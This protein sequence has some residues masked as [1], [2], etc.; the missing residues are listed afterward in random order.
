MSETGFDNPHTK[1]VIQTPNVLVGM[2]DQGGYVTD[3]LV[4]HPETGLMVPML[5]VHPEKL[6]RTGIPP[7]VPN[8]GPS[9][10]LGQ[11]GFGRESNWI[12]IPVSDTTGKM[13]LTHEQLSDEARA[14][15]PHK[16]QSEISVSITGPSSIRYQM[17]LKN[18]DNQPIKIVPGIHPYFAV[19]ENE[20]QN[21]KVHGLPAYNP[22]KYDWQQSFPDNEYRFNSRSLTV[23]MADRLITIRRLTGD[24]DANSRVTIWSEQGL[25]ALCVEPISGSPKRLMDHQPLTLHPGKVWVMD[26]EMSAEFKKAA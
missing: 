22:G 21:V 18:D 3:W 4:R 2:R 17:F 16:F 15:Y 7:L 10:R 23:E 14:K 20:R 19:P 1:F 24:S 26:L 9:E 8:Y 12:Y 5:F 25:P 6:K 11:H 13:L